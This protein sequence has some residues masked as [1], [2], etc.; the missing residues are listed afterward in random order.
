MRSFGLCCAALLLAQAPRLQ[1]QAET[2]APLSL[3]DVPFIS[4]SEALCGGAAAAMVLRYWG[5]RGVSAES[6]AHLVD[7][8]AAGIRTGALVADLRTRGWNATAIE[9]REDLVRAELSRGRPVLT[10]IEDRP[11][12]FH[13]LVV[14][15]WHERGVIFHDPARA[16]F[17]VMGKAEFE[18]RWRAADRWMAVV[19]PGADPSRSSVESPSIPISRDGAA[20]DRLIAEGVRHAQASDLGSA[21]RALTSALACPGSAAA[22]ELAGVRLLQRRWAEVSDLA[23]AAVAT[24]ADDAYAWKLLATSRFVQDDRL[25]ALDAWNRAGEPRVDLVRVDGLTRTRHR[26]VEQLLA[27]EAGEMLSA[28]KFVRA[29]RQLAELP[30]AASTR[31]NYAP[32]A[33]G[34]AE[35]RG[36]VA[37]RPLL[38]NSRL[39]LFAL[40]LS[41]AA[42]REARIVTGSWTGGGEQ[43]SAAWRF[44]PHR[45]RAAAEVRAP[46]PWAGVWGVEG[47]AEKQSFTSPAVRSAERSGAHMSVS[48]WA[49]GWLRWDLVAGIDRWRDVATFGSA[50]VGARLVSLGDRIHGRIRVS[51]WLGD[52]PFATLQASVQARSSMEPQGTVL[53]VSGAVERASADTPHDLWF[54]GDTGHARATLMRAHPVLEDGRLRVNQLGRAL[55]NASFEAQRWWPVRG[56]LRVGAAG[57]ADVARTSQRLDGPAETG[58]DAGVG[59]RIALPGIPGVFRVDLARGLRDGATALSFVYQ[60]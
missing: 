34:L 31:L 13:Y 1:A 50:G 15:A 42:T 29:R 12:T 55:L 57:F 17:R 22:R 54:A 4:Q 60:P 26:V 52:G 6:F 30:S 24:D 49:S 25:G 47:F 3:L 44:W 43:V 18:K 37:E 46:V 59:A 11:A 9:G 10:L 21:E 53:L 7:R 27:V 45:P 33:S 23:S 51:A 19:L 40:G 2:P 41:T 35:L 58:V 39:S 36:T 48:D 8:S 5:E 16:P 32:A 56:L 38:P 14:V 20:C 28:G